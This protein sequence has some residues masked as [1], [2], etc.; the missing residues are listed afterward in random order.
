MNIDF[1]TAATGEV[2]SIDLERVIVAHFKDDCFKGTCC[3]GSTF[4]DHV[5]ETDKQEI[6]TSLVAA[7]FLHE[8]TNATFY[9]AAHAANIIIM[10]K[11]AHGEV[12]LLVTYEDTGGSPLL[13]PDRPF[14]LTVGREELDYAREYLKSKRAPFTRDPI[15]A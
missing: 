9:N 10:D 8:E 1:T 4:S 11:N 12:R 2:R 14:Y 7:G 13:P 5:S 6:I 3:D 15:F